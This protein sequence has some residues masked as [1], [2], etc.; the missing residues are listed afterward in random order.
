[1]EFTL[2]PRSDRQLGAQYWDFSSKDDAPDLDGQEIDIYALWSI[3]DNFVFSPLVGWHKPEGDDVIA[4]QGNDDNNLYAQA[5]LMY[6][7]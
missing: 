7:Y 2:A 1:M 5:V 6:F 3:N 4:S